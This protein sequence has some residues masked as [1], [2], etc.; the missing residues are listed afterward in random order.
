[1]HKFGWIDSHAHLSNLDED[2]LKD[3]TESS[4]QN[5]VLTVINCATDLASAEIIRSQCL[6]VPNMYGA[7]GISPFDTINVENGWQDKLENLLSHP[8]FIALGEIGLDKTNP[9]YPDFEIQKKVFLDQLK[10]ASKLDIPVLVHSR[11]S[12]KEVLELLI[13]NKIKNAIFHCYTGPTDLIKEII[14]GGYYLSYSGI[15][16]FNKSPL[17]EQVLKTP[18]DRLFI[19]TDSPYLAPKPFRGK[20]NTPA[21][22]SIIGEKISTLKNETQEAVMK[23]L[24]INFKNLFQ[25]NPY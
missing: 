18:L 23:Q 14:N 19:E 21:Y 12:E 16:T 17:D 11:G 6:R 10:I 24:T 20:T 25:V 8:S 1:M 22:V 2:E 15:I 9:T 4:G 5:K 13:S 3:S 7:A